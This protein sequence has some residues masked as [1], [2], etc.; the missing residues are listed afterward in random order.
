VSAVGVNG[1]VPAARRAHT[2]FVSRIIGT[3][4][5]AILAIW[6]VVSVASGLVAT[7]KAFVIIGLIAVA[8]G[9]VVWL[10]AG[11]SGRS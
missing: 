1:C 2:G 4:V 5:G 10:L 6:L 9:V 7:I 8:V 3:I 11:R